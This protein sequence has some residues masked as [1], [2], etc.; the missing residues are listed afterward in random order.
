MKREIK[1]HGAYYKVDEQG[2]L[3]NPAS[4][5]EVQSD[6]FSIVSD[7]TEKIKMRYGENL[8]S[9]YL[10]GSVAASCAD[11]GFSDLDMFVLLHTENKMYW[12]SIPESKVWESHY[13]NQFAG[14]H[15]LDVYQSSYSKNFQTDYPA[16][17]CIVKTQSVCVYGEDIS[18]D[19]KA[20]KATD[21]QAIHIK[22]L[23]KDLDCFYENICDVQACQDVM[24]VFLRAAFDLVME[25][26]GRYTNSLY[27]CWRSFSE[28]YPEKEQDFRQALDWYLNPIANKDVLMSYLKEHGEW[29]YKEACRLQMIDTGE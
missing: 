29:L 3:M 4:I 9:V 16:L 22:W 14:F 25:K 10:R 7:I 19:I 1:A 18:K 21:M 2:F 27:F 26:D 5:P 20:Y 8:H 11:F 28:H 24:K 6:W 15:S 13:R 12:E 23:R 17:A